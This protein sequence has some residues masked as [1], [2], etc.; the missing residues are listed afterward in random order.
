M[1]V[2]EQQE[3]ISFL[4]KLEKACKAHNAVECYELLRL[5]N[6]IAWDSRIIMMF[7]RYERLSNIACKIIFE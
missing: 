5:A 7:R 3:A 6:N 1:N 2:K 4:N